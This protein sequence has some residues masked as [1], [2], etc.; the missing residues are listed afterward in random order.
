MAVRPRRRGGPWG[1]RGA[2]A[3]QPRQA[4]TRRNGRALRAPAGR[5][6]ETWLRRPQ[7]KRTAGGG[8]GAQGL[9]VWEGPGSPAVPRGHV[10]GH[11]L[12]APARAAQEDG[13][14]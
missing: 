6:A 10:Q 4:L 12:P 13:G 7:S 9:Q 1:A 2:R 14:Q 5:E 8:S 3:L 11:P